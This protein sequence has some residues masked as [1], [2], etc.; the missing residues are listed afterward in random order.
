LRKKQ[1][2]GMRLTFLNLVITVC[3]GESVQWGNIDCAS[4]AASEI[5]LSYSS[6]RNQEMAELWTTLSAITRF[7]PYFGNMWFGSPNLRYYP[8]TKNLIAESVTA[9]QIY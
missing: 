1:R 9:D 2:S 6:V 8:Q 5:R 4:S 7:L 3:T